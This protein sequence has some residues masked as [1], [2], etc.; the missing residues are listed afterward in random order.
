M[1]ANATFSVKDDEGDKMILFA[2][3]EKDL[4]EKIINVEKAYRELERPTLL[5]DP[6][7]K[8]L[9]REKA[10][11]ETLRFKALAANVTARNLLGNR[12]NEIKTEL[13]DLSTRLKS[14]RRGRTAVTPEP[15]YI[16]I[17]S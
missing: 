17:S 3:R 8:A 1:L 4:V 5:S 12:M 2:N 7:K 13:A 14:I 9:A 16:D 15:L 10:L 6:Q 11:I